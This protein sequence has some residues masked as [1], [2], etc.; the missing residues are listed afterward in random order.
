MP[1]FFLTPSFISLLLLAHMLEAGTA[2]AASTGNNIDGNVSNVLAPTPVFSGSYSAAPAQ[3]KVGQAITLRAILTDVSGSLWKGNVTLEVHDASNQKIFQKYF[4][5][6]SFAPGQQRSYQAVW[7]PT[8][9]GTY[10][11]QVGVFN[12]RW[13]TAYRWDT[14]ASLTINPNPNPNPNP[15]PIPDVTSFSGVNGSTIYVDNAPYEVHNPNKPYNLTNPDSQTLRFEA[16]SGECW[17][18][19]DGSYSDCISDGNA[20]RTSI[21]KGG[22]YARNTTINIS[23]QFML[24]PGSANTADWFQFLELFDETSANSPP[25]EIDLQSPQWSPDHNGDHMMVEVGW[26]TKNGTPTSNGSPINCDWNTTM[27]GQ[28]A[29]YGYAYLDANPL[30]RGRWYSMQIQIN[31][32]AG[33]LVVKRDGVQLFNYQGTLGFGNSDTYHLEYGIYRAP[34]TS[35]IQAV[36]YRNMVVSP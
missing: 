18:L 5:G 15:A 19:P 36:Q 22:N 28:S 27:E 8:S 7:I 2:F 13:T 32:A 1:R 33:T 26:F 21:Q 25:F 35:N 10:T 12:R 3:V 30:Q 23:Y 17:V 31:H 11:Y 29:C 6:Q 24:E 4:S 9:P 14:A 34:T 20:E 16:H